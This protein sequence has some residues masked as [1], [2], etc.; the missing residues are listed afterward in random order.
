MLKNENIICISSIDWDFNWQGH[1]ETMTTF[2][3]N[4]NRVLFIENTGVRA[5]NLKDIQRLRKRIINWFK[6]VKGFRREMDNLY[7]YSPIILPF[8][9]SRIANWINKYVMITPIRRWMKIM[10]FHNPIV[11]TFLPTRTALNIINNVNN[12]FL[13]CDLSGLS[14]LNFIPLFLNGVKTVYGSPSLFLNVPIST[15][16]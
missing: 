10:E 4:G 11:W 5:P 2:A 12:K 7:V 9:Y 16:K 3:K 13:I 6:S 15:N 8:P 1:Q 14:I